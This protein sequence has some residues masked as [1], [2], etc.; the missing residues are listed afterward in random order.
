[1]SRTSPE[2]A[3]FNASRAAPGSA[4]PR[5]P[6]KTPCLS[7]SPRLTPREDSLLL[8][9]SGAGSCRHSPLLLRADDSCLW[10]FSRSVNLTGP[11]GTLDGRETCLALCSSTPER[12]SDEEKDGEDDSCDEK[13]PRVRAASLFLRPVLPLRN[14]FPDLSL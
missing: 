1:M 11:D 3:V 7:P 12:R 8:S 10:K 14:D 13:K 2:H 4:A 6:G 5:I 9:F